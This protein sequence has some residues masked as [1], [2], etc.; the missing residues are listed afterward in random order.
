MQVGTWLQTCSCAVD[1]SASAY[2][3]QPQDS[4]AFCQQIHSASRGILCCH[5]TVLLLG[6]LDINTLKLGF[7]F[8]GGG[9]SQDLGPATALQPELHSEGASH[10]G[11]GG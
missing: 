4:T 7:P 10:C 6:V 2:Y 1:V 5:F 9:H 8:A 11:A 3:L